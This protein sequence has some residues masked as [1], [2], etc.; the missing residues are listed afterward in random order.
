MG[1][2]TVATKEPGDDPG[3][4]RFRRLVVPILVLVVL[5]GAYLT[6]SRLTG[7][8]SDDEGAEQQS[9]RADGPPPGREEASKPLGVPGPVPAGDGA[10]EFMEV[11][12]S[13]RDA[14]VAWDPCRPIHYVVNPKGQP[15]DGQ[16]MVADAIATVSRAT[17]LRFVADG[18]TTETPDKQRKAYQ[19]KRY[20]DRWAPVLIAWSDEASDPALAGY[21]AGI[22]GPHGVVS[23]EDGTVVSVTGDVLLD[24][25]QLAD[26]A[27]DAEA[28]V[29]H[30]L[31]HLVGL[32]H[33]SDRRQ[34]MFSEG[35]DGV[36]DFADGDLRGLAALGRGKCV[37]EV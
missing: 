20:G 32:D 7:S 37:P 19:P 30:E 12:P 2:H 9:G 6:V 16:R 35:Q 25:E 18:T 4:G 14:P 5:V 15:P 31:G 24:R 34:I 23:P 3:P 29:L 13:D 21:I 1:R 28:T 26:G 36:T 8:S 17:G 27:P 11:Q 10:F 33:V 22:S